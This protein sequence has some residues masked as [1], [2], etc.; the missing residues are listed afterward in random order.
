M[1]Y[2]DLVGAGK[3]CRHLQPQCRSQ[4]HEKRRFTDPRRTRQNTGQA[5]AGADAARAPAQSATRKRL[6]GCDAVSGKTCRRG[7]LSLFLTIETIR[8]ALSGM[9]PATPRPRGLHNNR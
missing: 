7:A 3:S 1:D 2:P 8:Q 6:R 4:I 5:A 9:V